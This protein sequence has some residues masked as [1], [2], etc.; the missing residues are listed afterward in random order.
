MSSAEAEREA[1]A[2]PPSGDVVA[3]LL[4]QH[5]RIRGLFAQIAGADTDGVGPDWAARSPVACCGPG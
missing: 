2:M 3:L 1:A 4:E 5:P